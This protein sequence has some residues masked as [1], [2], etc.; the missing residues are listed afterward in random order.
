[1]TLRF[2][3]LTLCLS[4]CLLYAQDLDH[5]IILIGDAGEINAKQEVLIPTAAQL[6]VQGKTTAYFLGDNIYPIGMELDESKDSL[7]TAILKS[8]FTPFRERGVPVY[9]MAGNHDWDKS[10]PKGLAKIKAQEAALKKQNDEGL[11]FVPA[12]GNLGPFVEQITPQ[13]LTVIYDSEFWLFPHHDTS[14][15]NVTVQKQHFLAALDSIQEK[16]QDK[17]ILVM[18]HH[19]MKSYGEHSLS[20]SVRDHL[21]PLRKLWKGLYLPLPVV[22]SAYP[23]LRSTLLKTAE[24]LKHPVYRELISSVTEIG[25][26][27]PNLLYISGH[28]HG[29]QF[30]KKGNFTQI[31]SGSGAKTSQIRSASD[32]LY[33]HGQQGFTTIDILR[34]GDLLIGFYMVQN[35]EVKQGF[36]TTIHKN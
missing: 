20:F 10:G 24:D 13:V 30:I 29:L 33:K 22:G 26:K 35:G 2:L 1:M 4:C 34:N 25:N 32:L 15:A 5:R 28:D 8:Q 31:V 18:S 3:F 7:S 9:F 21:F 19:P 6:S 11:H 23:L 36:S 12:A 17:I 14:Q 27:H 16:N